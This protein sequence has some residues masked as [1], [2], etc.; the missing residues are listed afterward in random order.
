MLGSRYRRV[1][2]MADHSN[3]RSKVKGWFLTYPNCSEHPEILKA[4]LEA[5]ARMDDYI[6]A[7]ESHADGS[8][9]LHA[10]IKYP[11]G[12][13]RADVFPPANSGRTSVFDFMGYHGHYEVPR[14]FKDCI[15]YC[16]KDGDFIT[17]LSG[18]Y[19]GG[20]HKKKQFVT[21]VLQKKTV[22]QMLAEGDIS[23]VQARQAV[24]AK[25]LLIEPYEHTGVRGVWIYGPPG[26][27]KTH[28][29]RSMANGERPFIK[30]Q[31]KWFD[32]YAGE[33]T[34]ILDDY[35][36]G[37]TLG[38]YLKIWLDKWA[39]TGEVK[40]ATVNL[41]HERFIITSNYSPEEMFPDPVMCEAI[42]RRCVIEKIETLV[43]Q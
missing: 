11:D 20:A 33:K 16:A 12:I 30:A 40:G 29:A 23:W 37:A 27:G 17:N 21:D 25:S 19:L 18:D 10:A 14:S 15:K 38:H 31:N 41:S 3:P 13:R 1:I 26:V 6:I 35:D 22:V 24:Y 2:S 34:I 43:I 9:H 8:L 39:C 5:V 7:R 42:K 32:G 36:C 4:H 28:K